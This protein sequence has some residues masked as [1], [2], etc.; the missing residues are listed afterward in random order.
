MDL[1]TGEMRVRQQLQK[2]GKSLVLQ[3][4][5]TEK[6]RRTLALPT[7][8]IDG[9][10]AH[11]KRQLEERLESGDRW[12]DTGLVFTSYR[13]TKEGKGRGMKI[14]AGLDPRNVSRTLHSLLEAAKLPRCR[15]HDLRHSAASLLIAEGIELAEISM[16]LGHSDSGSRPTSTDTCRSKR[17]RRRRARWTRCSPASRRLAVLR[18][19]PET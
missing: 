13:L 14:G 19:E 4:L 5:K 11:R 3:P 18:S 7:L 10:K 15:F 9:L 17:P 16:L 12:I 8:C 6:S 1:E 2:V